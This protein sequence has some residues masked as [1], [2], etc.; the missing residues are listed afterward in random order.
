[1][2]DIISV[3]SHSNS[4]TSG[5]NSSPNAWEDEEFD[6]I[7]DVEE[8]EVDDQANWSLGRLEEYKALQ[9][10]IRWMG[11]DMGINLQ[12]IALKGLGIRFKTCCYL[13]GIFSLNFNLY[14]T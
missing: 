14:C 4:V 10:S 13:L 3:K 6:G 11:F 7:K 8:R 1:M 9:S 12:D 2:A 5:G